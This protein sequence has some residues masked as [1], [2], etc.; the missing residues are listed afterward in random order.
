MRTTYNITGIIR[1][2]CHTV[3]LRYYYKLKNFFK[4]VSKLSLAL[5]YMFWWINTYFIHN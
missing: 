1:L 4:V 5:V 2:Y 3:Q